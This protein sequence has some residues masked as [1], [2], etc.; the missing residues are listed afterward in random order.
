MTSMVFVLAAVAVNPGA[1]HFLTDHPA[2][3][4]TTAPDGHLTHASGFLAETG[5]HDAESAARSFL[6]KYEDEFGV[7][8][9]GLELR[10]VP[11]LGRS[12]AVK[13]ARTIGGMQLFGGDVT[14]GVD[15][16]HRVFLVN[17]GS[18]MGF[19]SGSHLVGEQ[20]AHKAALAAV[21]G[22]GAD[23]GEGT[24][25]A[26]YRTFLNSTRAVYRVDFITPAGDWRTFVDGETGK[27]LFRQNLRD[28]VSAPGSVYD[29]SPVESA[30]ALC[31]TT[32]TSGVHTECNPVSSVTVINLV[33]GNDLTGTQTMTFNCDGK[34][35]P[36]ARSGLTA[37]AKITPVSGSFA[38]PVDST[39][40]STTDN[41]SGVMAY[42]HLD[43][44]VTFFKKLDPTLP[45]ADP[46]DVG[47]PLA[48][49]GAMPGLVNNFD[50]NAPLENAFFSGPLDAMVFG[51]GATADYSYDATV[52]YHE[53]THGVVFAWGGYG[54]DI[55]AMGG[56]D[57][58]SA[59][60]EGTAD[61]MAVSETGHSDI[62]A[63]I[64][65]TEATPAATLRDM[66]DPNATRSCKGN[67]TVVS[68]FGGLEGVNGFDGEVHDDGEIWNGFYWEVFDGLRTAGFK[69]CSGACEAAPEIMYKTIQLAAGV[70]DS[71]AF[72]NYWQT[73]EAAAKAVQPTQPSVA[74]YADCVAKRRGFDQC[75]GTVPLYA[76]EV[77]NQF[78]RLRYSPYQVALQITGAAIFQICDTQGLQTTIYAQK[79]T[80]LQLSNIDPQTGAATVVTTAKTFAGSVTF[81]APCSSGTESL[82][83]GGGQ[84]AGV[85][86][87][88]IDSPDALEGGNPGQDIY[89]YGAFSTNAN[90]TTAI[91]GFAARPAVAAPATCVAPAPFVITSA[92]A[93][94]TPGKSTTLTAAGGSN[95]G[96]TWSI[97]TNASGGSIVASTGAYTAGSTPNVTD[98]VQ[99]TDSLGD[100][101]TQSVAVG[102]APSSGGCSSTGSSSVALLAAMAMILATRRRRVSL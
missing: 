29:I 83:I 96:I 69:G 78:V 89:Q 9:E 11:E 73:F 65:A 2:A 13:F 12:G 52:M 75:D 21:K 92:A 80:P 14:V 35:E 15:E 63:F 6:G 74:A 79:D 34:N 70:K 95:T 19:V 32:G 81:T 72:N 98:V 22:G 16:R 55:T 86:Y 90:P 97:A 60:N 99:A 28:H 58:P 51:Q 84:G 18:S 10:G 8:S 68:Q 3:A 46:N 50:A 36:T 1:R 91:A 54:S 102:P 47:H 56:F 48:I 27:V 93:T 85:Y 49:R 26:G 101:A 87:L 64:G 5:A 44:H 88:L 61:S 38:F 82:N 17:S 100:T 40:K 62:G 33:D 71:P 59:L 4:H 57:E 76:G 24:I 77:K 20:A 37:C 43:E 23:A 41:F 7:G 53:Y 30:T 66:N 45:P 42:F 31:A 67:G 39:F 25:V 94:V